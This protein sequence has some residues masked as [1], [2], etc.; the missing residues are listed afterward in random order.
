MIV[1]LC[2][3]RSLIRL[4]GPVFDADLPSTKSLPFN[5]VHLLID[6]LVFIYVYPSQI[7]FTGPHPRLIVLARPRKM[8]RRRINEAEAE[9][10][11]GEN[12]SEWR[13]RRSATSFA[14]V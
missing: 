3:E 7:H 12:R 8:M 1:L 9:Q 11:N 13:F 6:S 4:F 10:R 14:L 2:V 5:I